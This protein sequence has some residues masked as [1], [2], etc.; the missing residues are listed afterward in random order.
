MSSLLVEPGQLEAGRVLA[1]DDADAHHLRVR[2]T[3]A[4]ERVRALD[5]A[6]TVG[7]GTLAGSNGR[8]EVRID[9]VS[10][11]ARPAPLLVLVGA[12]DRDRFGWLVEKATELGATAIVAVETRR[13][14]SVAGRVRPETV[15]RFRRR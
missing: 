5:G 8:W 3:G 14:L 2:R 1:V 4:G 9:S 7:L 6:G 10:R 11:V 15:E 12:G 13:S